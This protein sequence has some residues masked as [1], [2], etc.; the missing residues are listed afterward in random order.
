MYKILLISCLIL[1]TSFL[2]AQAQLNVHTTNGTTTFNLNEITDITFSQG[3]TPGQMVLVPGG[4]F[5]MGDTH[6]GAIEWELPTH[7]VTLSSFMIGKYELTQGEWEAVMGAWNSDP[8]GFGTTYGVGSN[9][10]VYYVSRYDILKYCNLRSL[11][12][13]LTP[14][15]TISGST[16]P[17]AWGTVPTS[18]NDATWDA[19]ISNWTANGY[20]LPTEAEWE[21]AARGGTSTPDY[22][23]IGSDDVNAVAWYHPNSGDTSHPVGTK[24]PNALGIYDMSGNVYEWCWDWYGTYSSDAQTNP[25]GAV[26]GPNRVL[27]GSY[28]GNDAYDCRVSN[29][30][31]VNPYVSYFVQGVRLCRAVQ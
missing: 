11:N 24:A 10:P 28:W 15:Y 9:Y 8:F 3:T 2:F 23:Y 21:F 19:A 6:G 18:G 14:V 30:Y 1:F 31:Y 27:R 22:L 20:R 29:R 12:E 7:S 25:Q 16:N 4:T 26:S 17:T 13:G 5:T